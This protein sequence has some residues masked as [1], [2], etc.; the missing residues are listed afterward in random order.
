MAT[1]LVSRNYIIGQLQIMPNLLLLYVEYI[2]ECKC[3]CSPQLLLRLL[4]INK[5]KPELVPSNITYKIGAEL[6]DSELLQTEGSEECANVEDKA[7]DKDATGD[8]RQ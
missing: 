4:T 7:H 6:T 1:D 8:H 5:T 3:P 2:T